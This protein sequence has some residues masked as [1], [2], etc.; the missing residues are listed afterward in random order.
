[1][2]LGQSTGGLLRWLATKARGAV[3]T[4]LSRHRPTGP[5]V[6][7]LHDKGGPWPTCLA[8]HVAQITPQGPKV[9]QEQSVPSGHDHP[10]ASGYTLSAQPE[11][12]KNI[13]PGP[14]FPTSYNLVNT[15][16]TTEK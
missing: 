12:Y 14:C 10:K 5:G 11:P 7:D 16:R 6:A 2:W 15:C 13:R 9:H 8:G 1:M 3:N 4:G